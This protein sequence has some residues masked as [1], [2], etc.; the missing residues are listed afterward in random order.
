AERSGVGIMIEGWPVQFLPVATPLDEEALAQAIEVDFNH[1]GSPPLK[2]RVLR[3][4][5]VVATALSVGRLKDYARIEDFLDQGALDLQALKGVLQRHNLLAKWRD[6]L[7]KA[8]KPDP[9]V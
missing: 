4:E 7:T 8:G 5:H 6:F 2:S 3:A 9:L 1:A